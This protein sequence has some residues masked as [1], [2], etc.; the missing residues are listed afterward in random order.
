MMRGV[1]LR[2]PTRNLE[3]DVRC[4][5]RSE[6]EGCDG[7]DREERPA[8]SRREREEI[9]PTRIC[10][11]DDRRKYQR[12]GEHH[13]RRDRIDERQKAEDEAGHTEC[14]ELQHGWHPTFADE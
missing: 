8:R 2:R 1:F 5:R 9:A 4:D 3:T 7:R 11:H 14:E 10:R 6:R 12:H 13:R